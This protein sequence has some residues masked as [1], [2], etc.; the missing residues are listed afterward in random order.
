MM[1]SNVKNKEKD[2]KAQGKKTQSK[3]IGKCAGK[4]EASARL[5]T[6]FG[7]LNQTYIYYTGLY[8]KAHGNGKEKRKKKRT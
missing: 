8:H 2:D 4:R 3:G 5:R 6:E 7:N 1:Y